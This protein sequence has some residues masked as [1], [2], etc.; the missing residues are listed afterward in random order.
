MLEQIDSLQRVI[1]LGEGVLERPAAGECFGLSKIMR[2]AP[3]AR[4]Q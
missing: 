1:N 4:W 3:R 2:S